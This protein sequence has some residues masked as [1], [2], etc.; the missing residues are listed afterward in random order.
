SINLIRRAA[1]LGLTD[2]AENYA[3]ELLSK[4]P[5][6]LDKGIRWHFIGKLQSNKVK[7]VLPY[8]V[9]IHSVDSLE[10]AQKIG[11]AKQD[12]SVARDF[13][14]ILLQVNQGGERQKS[15]LPPSVVDKLFD[16]FLCIEGVQVVGLMTIPPRVY[17]PRRA[18]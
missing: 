8:V 18:K 17:D 5:L 15:G 10:L 16:E 14:P 1:D 13:I 3:Q 7:H 12:L 9:S 2:M 11:R 4:A 6:C